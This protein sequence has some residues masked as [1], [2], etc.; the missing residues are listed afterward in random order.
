M[1]RQTRALLAVQSRW[2]SE[3]RAVLTKWAEN[4]AKW[5]AERAQLLATLEAERAVHAAETRA[6]VQQLVEASALSVSLSAEG[7]GAQHA[8]LARKCAALEAE[9]GE[10]DARIS[11]L[12]KA[13]AAAQGAG[14]GASE[15][16]PR[17]AEVTEA[18]SP[19]PRA[20]EASP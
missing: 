3:R 16:L 9:L 13:L 10:R 15:A 18:S 17:D 20:E 2:E 1:D 6:L 8:A 7:G 11:A 14:E 5:E 19:Q 12:E 4:Q